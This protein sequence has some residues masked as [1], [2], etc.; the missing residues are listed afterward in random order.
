VLTCEDHSAIGG[1]GSGVLELAAER[2]L[3]A[4]NVR[5]LGLPDRFIAHAARLEQLTE[6]GLDATTMAATLRDMIRARSPRTS[7]QRT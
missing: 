7:R 3:P 4:G 6:A 5:V 1:F 2:G